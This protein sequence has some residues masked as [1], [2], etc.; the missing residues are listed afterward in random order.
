MLIAKKKRISWKKEGEKIRSSITWAETR[1]SW[2][3]RGTPRLSPI[4]SIHLKFVF[5]NSSLDELDVEA[6]K[7]EEE[8][9]E[10]ERDRV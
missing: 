5:N 7:K 3:G 8:E 2:Q 10:E 4:S 6:G 1:S 9:E